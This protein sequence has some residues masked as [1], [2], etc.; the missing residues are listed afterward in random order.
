MRGRD[1]V[2]FV[3][4]AAVDCTDGHAGVQCFLQPT[5]LCN[6]E[7]PILYDC[8]SGSG[9][10]SVYQ[11]GNRGLAQGSFHGDERMPL[12]CR[13]PVFKQSLNHVDIAGSEASAT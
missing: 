9:V 2:L 10:E 13:S 4:Q 8:T 6:A 11:S 12:L 5:R 1:G 3:G 7:L